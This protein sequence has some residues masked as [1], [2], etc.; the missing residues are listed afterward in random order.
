[1]PEKAQQVGQDQAKKEPV[2]QQAPAV[3]T[4]QN[5]KEEEQKQGQKNKVE[6]DPASQDAMKKPK[7]ELPA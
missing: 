2:K 4:V 5:Q 3:P 7:L 6:H 1:M